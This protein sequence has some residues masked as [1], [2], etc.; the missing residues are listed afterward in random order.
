[1][2]SPSSAD[3]IVQLRGIRKSFGSVEVL[4]GVSL[5]IAR[6]EVVVIIGPS[7]SGKSTLLR[8][9]NLLGAPDHGEVIFESK[10]LF[11]NGQPPVRVTGGGLYEARK[12]I[13]MVFQHANLFVHRTVL[14]NVM[15]GPVW[16]RKVTRDKARAEAFR[17]SL[18]DLVWQTIPISVLSNCRAVEQQR[19]AICRALA[20][21]PSVMLFDEPTASLDPELVGEVL[22]MMK[23]LADEGMTMMVVTHEMGFARRVADRV[24]FM[25]NGSIR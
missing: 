19:V 7:G 1:M 18:H 9:V 21:R 8:T 15:E 11:R 14:E 24:V 23:K 17:I 25:D 12:E 20:M 4:R 16:V 13:G 3:L 6:G 22:V 10:T 5:D 2:T